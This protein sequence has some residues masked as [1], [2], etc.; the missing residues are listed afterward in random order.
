MIEIKDTHEKIIQILNDKGPSLP[1]QIAKTVGLSSLFISAFLSELMNE[2]KVRISHLKVGG[3]HLY[4]LPNQEPLL[5]NFYK[6]LHPK[7]AEVFLLLKEK[8]ILKDSEQEP[9]IRVALRNIRDF[10]IGFKKNDE[11]YW[12]YAFIPESEI[13]SFFE[14]QERAKPEKKEFQKTT[15][16][17]KT[18][19]EK[20]EYSKIIEIEKIPEK[21]KEKEVRKKQTSETFL[22][23]VKFYLEQKNIELV[24]LEVYDKKEL[25]AKI[26]FNS[27]PEKTHLLFAYNKKR[28]TDK[29]IL[30]AY[31]K[32]MKY[33]LDYLILFK[34]EFS[35]KLEETIRAYK[36]LILSDKL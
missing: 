9:A 23:E 32:S 2:K 13:N 22:Q 8:K 30:K 27:S 16:I 6:Y 31:K 20:T 25:I 1:I 17:E 35:K 7:E 12:R 36:K 29:E 34:G 33:N 28:I 24:N 14:F 11:I 18:K 21:Q 3:S 5:E 26:R 10:A 4:F 19:P 15:E